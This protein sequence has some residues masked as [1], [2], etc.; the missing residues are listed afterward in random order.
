MRA[1]GRRWFLRW[2]GRKKGPTA[3]P[4]L[5]WVG[6]VVS[7]SIVLLAAFSWTGAPLVGNTF[8]HGCSDNPFGCGA[9]VEFLGTVV[10]VAIAF[11]AFTYWRVFVI[12][13]HHRR[14]AH[15]EVS[16]V[17]HPTESGSSPEEATTNPPRVVG[18][19]S[20]CKILEEDLRQETL[21]PQ[22]IAGGVGTGKTAVLLHLAELLA[23]RGAVPVPIR[24][25]EASADFDFLDLAKTRFMARVQP[26]LL[27]DEEG[28][29]IWRRLCYTRRVVVLADGLDEA[30]IGYPARVQSIRNAL[31][32]AQEK[33][34]PLVIASRPDEALEAID[35]AVIRLESLAASDVLR[36][37]S[38][39][40]GDEYRNDVAKLAEVG[41]VAEAPFYL[42][43]IRE[44]P[45]D[46]IRELL[47]RANGRTGFR[48]ELLEKWTQRLVNRELIGEARFMP[49]RRK[50]VIKGLG[51]IACDALA[52]NTLELKLEGDQAPAQ[53]DVA[54]VAERLGLVETVEHGIRFRHSTMQAYLGARCLP[55]VLENGR[56]G[57]EYKRRAFHEPSREFLTA[58][59]MSC[60]ME[61]NQAFRRKRRDELRDA[62]ASCRASDAERFDVLAAG[63]EID[64]LLGGE[65][66]EALADAAR[67]AWSQSPPGIG[68][69]NTSGDLKVV[70]S[71]LSAVSEMRAAATADAYS[72]LW[73]ICLEEDSYRIRLHAAQGLGGAGAKSLEALEGEIVQ[74]LK[75]GEALCGDEGA[76]NAEWGDVRL[77][78]LQ[79]WILP[80]LA[81]S[82]A[83]EGGEGRV[84]SERVCG[85][86]DRWVQL[87]QEDLHLGVQACLAQGFKYEANRRH[88][89]PR[90]RER[91]VSAA[92][93][94]LDYKDQTARERPSPPS[95]WYSQISLLQAFALWSLPSESDRAGLLPHISERMRGDWHPFIQATAS[96]CEKA[97]LEKEGAEAQ[98][99]AAASCPSRYVWIDET[100]I[101]AKIGAESVPADSKYWVPRAAGW[102][103]LNRDARVL[104]ADVFLLLNLIERGDASSGGDKTACVNVR[105]GRRRHVSKV[106]R[107]GTYLP[108]CIRHATE[109][110]R[111]LGASEG[112]ADQ[113]G[114]SSCADGCEFE[115]EAG[116]GLCP[117]PER[118]QLPFRGELGETF[119][120]EQQRLFRGTRQRLP[121]WVKSDASVSRLS[122]RNSPPLPAFWNYLEERAREPMKAGDDNATGG[123]R[124]RSVHQNGDSPAPIMFPIV[125]YEDIAAAMEWLAAAF[126]FEKKREVRGPQRTIIHAEMTLGDGV[127]ML[128]PLEGD[129]PGRT[130]PQWRWSGEGVFISVTELEAHC[131]RAKLSGAEIVHKLRSTA[132]GTKE[133]SARDPEG[134]LWSFGTGVRPGTKNDPRP[135]AVAESV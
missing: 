4:L 113:N 76:T 80:L 94:L 64:A 1:R 23:D 70:E 62:I 51:P 126:C 119:C 25:R 47:Q 124:E 111:L 95:W 54:Q 33:S 116:K 60:C 19:D 112:E 55:A 103:S 78:S 84:L 123:P 88:G 57:D 40:L 68:A 44:I 46:T 45:A 6:I 22:V 12:A 14:L 37:L 77:C 102:R 17:V 63:Y 30:L 129:D 118:D 11:V 109:R 65:G 107:D 72:A 32:A 97:V 27:T 18:R 34:L 75:R 122:R 98:T 131:E 121:R 85:Y 108:S 128:R 7:L 56:Q 120:R 92:E 9:L 59:V 53:L 93:S 29:K 69:G 99:D 100:N 87:A 2:R 41:E 28:Q 26:R 8:E 135:A 20:V 79:G 91:L 106:N 42:R 133:Y 48:V 58:V 117:Y 21:R 104:V 115:L 66:G 96:L 81:S 89:D 90:V 86:V 132:Y 24:L 43:V 101:V 82:C 71:K 67:L 38:E 39:V 31:A 49:T 5:G 73:D 130:P 3:T 16:R 35:A 114:P 105:E 15:K 83:L 127:V 134:H 10:A 52:R 74:A 125:H 13:E 61:S 50:A 110:T 36:Y